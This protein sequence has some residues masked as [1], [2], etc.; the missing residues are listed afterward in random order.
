M[1]TCIPGLSPPEITSVCEPSLSPVDVVA[2]EN[3]AAYDFN[4]IEMPP[5]N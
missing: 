2:M 5:A 1:I 4:P 3:L